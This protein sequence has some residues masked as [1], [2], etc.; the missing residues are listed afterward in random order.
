MAE[1]LLLKWGT[2]KGWNLETETSR[3]AA[4]TYFETGQH[5]SCVMAQHDTP[6]MKE[7]L[8]GLIDAVADSG[9]TIIND[10]SGDTLTADEAKD[11][12]RTYGADHG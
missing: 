10:W 8:C 9:G 11:Y 12:I 6:E 7:A 4:R 1:R 5:A 2:L 3:D